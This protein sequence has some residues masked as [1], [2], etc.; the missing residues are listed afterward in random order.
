LES[1]DSEFDI[2]FDRIRLVG[3]RFSEL[4]VGLPDEALKADSITALELIQAVELLSG[5]GRQVGLNYPPLRKWRDVHELFRRLNSHQSTTRSPADSVDL[6]TRR[7]RWVDLVP[8]TDL[9]GAFSYHLALENPDL[10]HWRFASHLPDPQSFLQTSLKGATC[11]LVVNRRGSSQPI[12]LVVLHSFSQTS[13]YA[14]LSI[15]IKVD[16]LVP[17]ITID[18]FDTALKYIFTTW[19]LR[20]IYFYMADYAASQI[21]DFRA[22]GLPHEE[23]RLHDYF[24][25]QN[26]WHDL[27]ILSVYRDESLEELLLNK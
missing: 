21:L 19:D 15:G 6:V 9:H 7:G 5:H 16:E 3:S 17:G 8:Y 12:G 1:T 22:L 10:F 13:G 11:A 27:L 24:Y 4:T 23:G 25:Y 2:L 26:G 14:S 18:I 20:K